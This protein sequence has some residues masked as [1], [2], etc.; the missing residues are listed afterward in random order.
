MPHKV[1]FQCKIFYHNFYDF[2]VFIRNQLR[3][4]TV[5]VLKHILSFLKLVTTRFFFAVILILRSKND[6]IVY[7]YV[8][9]VD[10]ADIDIYR[11]RPRDGQSTYSKST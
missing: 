10:E 4:R 9:N 3:G 8:Y 7:N 11:S 5:R 1:Q 2:V 6:Y